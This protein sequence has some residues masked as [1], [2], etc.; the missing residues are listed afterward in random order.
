MD[1]SSNSNPSSGGDG[2]G[3]G[4][5]SSG[6]SIGGQLLNAGDPPPRPADP[7]PR[8]QGRYEFSFHVPLNPA[9][10]GAGGGGPAG[11]EQHP[12][13]TIQFEFGFGPGARPPGF[14]PMPPE[15]WRAQRQQQGEA[16]GAAGQAGPRVAQ[17]APGFERV[18]QGRSLGPHSQYPP[19]MNAEPAQPPLSEAARDS[20]NPPPLDAPA[21]APAPGNP[22]VLPSERFHLP[23][24]FPT[25]QAGRPQ[26]PTTDFPFPF[27]LDALLPSAPVADPARAVE[28]LR[29]LKDPGADMMRRIDRVTRAESGEEFK[30]AVCMEA[31]ED[32]VVAMEGGGGDADMGAGA[33]GTQADEGEV[34]KLLNPSAE[35]SVEP[36]EENMPEGGQTSM[37]AFPCCHIFHEGCLEPWLQSKTT[38]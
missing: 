11:Q 7:I 2:G 1:A 37:R 38:W 27:F 4:S 26:L 28:L 3:E 9:G 5:A 34:E 29:G 25:M 31:W 16:L 32:E 15:Q 19:G 24:P 20:A 35:T 30:C 22:P 36:D 12:S 21:P 13:L 17:G 23:L 6:E 33:V 10:L 14:G 8:G 18:S